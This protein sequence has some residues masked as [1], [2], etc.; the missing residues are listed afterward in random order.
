MDAPEVTAAFFDG[1][2]EPDDELGWRVMVRFAG[3]GFVKA[4]TPLVAT[5]GDLPVEGLMIQ[6][7]GGAM[8][9]LRDIPPIGARLK[10]GYLDWEIKDTDFAY[11]PPVA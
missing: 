2:P 7:E 6:G 5:V 10:V 3:T 8:G 4:A 11:S 9:F 1:L